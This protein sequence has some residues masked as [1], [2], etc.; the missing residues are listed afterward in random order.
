MS[1]FPIPRA[2]H[3]L[4][5][6]VLVL[7]PA[8]A[9][10]LDL[11]GPAE[12][13]AQ[14]VRLSSG[15][16]YEIEVSVVPLP[17]GLRTTSSGVPLS[18]GRSLPD[19]IADDRP[20][21]TLI[22]AGGEGARSR[23]DEPDLRAAVSLLAGRARRVASVCTGAFVLAATGLLDGKRAVTHWRW[24]QLL[25]RTYPRIR[26]EPDPIYVQDGGIWTSAGVTAGMDLAL[27]LVEEDHGHELALAIAR[28]L[29][30]FLRRPGGQGQFS[31]ALAAQTAL[32]P[33]MQDLVAW[34]ADNLHR[35]LTVETLADRM[36]FSPRQFARVFARELGMPPGL[37]VDRMRVEA[38]RRQLEEA[39]QGL[40]AVAATCGFGTEETMRRAFL[41]HLGIPPGAYRD[42]FRR[43]LAGDPPAPI[44]E[45]QA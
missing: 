43:Q 17:S 37:M 44:Q 22:L 8:P 5:K 42:R 31:T 32:G 1:K 39:P 16:L 21:D 15:S 29:V 34:I 38:A 30:M 20:L 11:A 26:V 27:A 4:S 9:Q 35:P 10:L 33:S 24:C 40:S 6:R 3:H 19:L 23:A 36:R 14:A 45:F 18:A 2:P 28:E 12:V 41:R 7:A 25:A 13:F